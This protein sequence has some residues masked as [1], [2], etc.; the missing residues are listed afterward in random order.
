MNKRL[1]KPICFLL[2]SLALGFILTFIDITNLATIV[3]AEDPKIK[4]KACMQN[5]E[6]ARINLQ[7]AETQ[8]EFAKAALLKAENQLQIALIEQQSYQE[9]ISRASILWNDSNIKL[10][11]IASHAQIQFR[12]A[13]GLSTFNHIKYVEYTNTYTNLYND[14]RNFLDNQNVEFISLDYVNNFEMRL[15]QYLSNINLFLHQLDIEY[16]TAE[17]NW[18]FK[19][20]KAKKTDERKHTTKELDYF[21]EKENLLKKLREFPDKPLIIDDIME[22]DTDLN[23]N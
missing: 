1:K 19:L 4:T 15:N 14:L 23:F 11:E 3:Q 12:K 16:A 9:L 17:R 6:N 8:L 13:N 2:V 20:D 22:S 5:V 18:Y 21:F 10:T 7:N